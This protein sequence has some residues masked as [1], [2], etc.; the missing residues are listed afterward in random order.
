MQAKN[1]ER[2]KAIAPVSCLSSEPQVEIVRQAPH[3][4]HPGN[5]SGRLGV[6]GGAF[7]PI[8]NA[9]LVLGA[10]ARQVFHLTEVLFLLPRI[11]PHKPIFGASLEERLEMM[12][13]AVEDCPYCSVG[14]SSHGLFLDICRGLRQVYPPSTL[15]YFLTGRDAAERILTWEYEDPPTALAEM[16]SQFELIVA[17]REGAFQVPQRADILR[18]QD[19][20]HRLALPDPYREISS[21]QVRLSVAQ[22]ESIEGLVPPTVAAY[23]SQK[24]LYRESQREEAQERESKR[25]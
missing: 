21:T 12:I 1:Q 14:W 15:L 20:I 13:L 8:T 19:K 16:F 25:R 10:E 11:P 22:G 18:Y 9:H 2:S 4:I 24:G 17:D 5:E 7:N 23:I 3:G 6:L